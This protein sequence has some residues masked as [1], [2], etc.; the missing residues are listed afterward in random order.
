LYRR[1][2][3]AAGT[4][5]PNT[6]QFCLL[7]GLLLT[8]MPDSKTIFAYPDRQTAYRLNL[9]KHYCPRYNPHKEK[10]AAGRSNA[11]QFNNILSI[12]P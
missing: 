1:T 3:E 9:A 8:R 7:Y 4:A 2:G 10:H 12:I 5:A 6:K 11:V